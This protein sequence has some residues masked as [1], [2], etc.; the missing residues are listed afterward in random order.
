MVL[1]GII[2]IQSSILSRYKIK[3]SYSP[4]IIPNRLGDK[5]AV[6]GLVSRRS[7]LDELYEV[8]PYSRSDG[9][10]SRRK[11]QKSFC[12]PHH[13]RLPPRAD[14][15]RSTSVDSDTSNGM[16]INEYGSSISPSSFFIRR[17]CT[18]CN[19]LLVPQLTQF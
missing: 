16:Q 2:K 11:R 5:L 13:Q 15:E 18:D 1:W 17:T 7:E 8:F 3:I 10:K 12:M 4:T 6:S 19:S 14:S 9:A